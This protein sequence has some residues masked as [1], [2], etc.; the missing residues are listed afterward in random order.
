MSPPATRLATT[1]A[2]VVR[3]TSRRLTV[4]DVHVR[5]GGVRALN[6]VS[7]EVGAGDV[8]G[9]MGPNG[10]GKTTLI[11]AVTGFIRLERGTILLDGER[12]DGY[13]PQRRARQGLGRTFQSLEL[14]EEFTVLENLRTA[15][16]RRDS[17]AYFADLVHPKAEPLPTTAIAAVQ[18]FS[19]EEDLDRRPSE[20]PYGRRRQVAIAR[21]VAANPSILLL[22][23]PAAGL[24]ESE[25][26][27][28]GALIR[29]LAD[30]W[31]MGILLV[32]H[33]VP[34]LTTVCDNLVV[35]DF[36]NEIGRGTPAEIRS[37]PRVVAAYL[38][39]A[40]DATEEV[41]AQH[42]D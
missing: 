2:T 41:G 32:E 39:E 4:Q 28:L 24:N 22:D 12:I 36:G 19:L 29:E 40:L 1:E 6:G 10:A 14:F 37:D 25:T 31:G 33:D 5:F 35:I 34:M 23:E 18:M 26:R 8:V 16:D 20:L 13:T 21:A 15:S 3:V 30:Q 17:L 9:L 27:A 11:D 42:V 7:L 38:G